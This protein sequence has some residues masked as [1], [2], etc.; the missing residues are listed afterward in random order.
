MRRGYSGPEIGAGQCLVARP[1]PNRKAQ[2][3]KDKA[4]RKIIF[5][6][7]TERLRLSEKHNENIEVLGAT[8]VTD[9]FPAQ[10]AIKQ[11]ITIVGC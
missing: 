6:N 10:W 11:L 1:R 8:K 7:R 4:A 2:E 5:G 9:R 3:N